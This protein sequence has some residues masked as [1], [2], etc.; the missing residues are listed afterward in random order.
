V[1]LLLDENLSPRLIAA[2][3]DLYSGSLHVR[4]CGL[5]G[6]SDAQIWR[7]AL[8]NGFAIVSKDSDFAQRSLLLGGP[9]KVIW[10]RIETVRQRVLTL[11]FATRLVA[12]R[13]S[14]AV[15]KLVW[16]LHRRSVKPI[17]DDSMSF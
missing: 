17:A 9:P 4:D 10:L 2:L 3:Q 7:Y 13:R 6:A 11:Y 15:M 1:K 14:R 12:S 16:Y 8:E 5:R